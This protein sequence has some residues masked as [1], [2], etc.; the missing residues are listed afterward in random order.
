MDTTSD[1]DVGSQTSDI[2]DET[3]RV[4]IFE[5]VGAGSWPIR[6]AFPSASA[7]ARWDFLN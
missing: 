7:K 2:R 1:A 6:D 3:V 4:G 5:V